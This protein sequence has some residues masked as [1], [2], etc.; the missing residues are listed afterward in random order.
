MISS[1]KKINNRGLLFSIFLFSAFT[2][3]F[4]STASVS[5]ISWN[6]GKIIDDAVFTNSNAMDPGSIQN[7]LNSKVPS[8]DTWGTQPSEFGGGTRAQYGASRGNPAP[9][10]CLK[11][12]SEGGRSAAQIIYDTGQEFQINP[13]VL[14]VLLQKEQGLVTDTWP[15]ANQYRTATGYGCPDSTPGVCNSEYYGFTNQV[16]WAARMFRAIMNNSPTWYTPYVL[17]NNYIQYNPEPSC[18]G[19]I[20]NI[21][22]RSTQALYNYTPYQPNQ[23]ALDAGWGT[24]PCG[25]YGNRNFKLYFES[26][27]G[28]L[29][30][31]N[32]Y[33]AVIK[34]P[35]SPA[36]YLQTS[37]G[38]YYIP[39]GE[40]L[41]AWG[42]D[43]LTPKLVAQSYLDSLPNHD[44]LDRLLKDDWGN[45]FFIDGAK[46]HYIRSQDHLALWNFNS[47]KAAQSLGL[48]YTMPGGEW[49]GRFARDAA[50]PNTVWLV[51]RGKKRP[52]PNGDILYQWGYG[53][54][55]HTTVSTA[56]LN[57][58]PTIADAGRYATDGNSKYII[59]MGRKLA[60]PNANTDNAL[61]GIQ[62][63][64]SYEAITL[65]HLRTENAW[66]FV[67]NT[68]NGRWYML[69][70]GKK[71][72]IPNGKLATIWGRSPDRPLTTVSDGYLASLTN[73]GDL[74]YAVQ[75]TN[76]SALWLI[77]G[78][79]HTIE[80]AQ[81]IHAWLG[82]TTPPVY[83][84]QSLA[85]LA[86][87]PTAGTVI[88]GYGSQF[89]YIMDGGKKRYLMSPNARNAW[90]HSLMV[91]ANEFVER[92]P[93][94]SFINY[95]VKNVSGQGYLLMNNVAY[96]IDPAFYDAWGISGTTPSVSD[97]TI[98]RY[99]TGQT[100]KAFIK[101]GSTSYVMINGNK[102]AIKQYAD[103][104][105]PS[106]LGEI[107]LPSDYFGSTSDASYLVKSN[108][109]ADGRMW[110]ITGGKKLL[111]DTFEQKVSYGY[112]SQG[113]QP[114]PLSPAT[115]SL[116]PNDT[117]S[118]SLLLQTGGTGVKF[119]SFGYALG[120]SE[121][122]TLTNAIGTSNPILQ[123]SPSVFETFKLRRSMT[124]LL[125]DDQG[126]LYWLESGNKRHLSS[127]SA[128]N[129]YSSTQQTYLEGTTMNLVPNGA[130]IN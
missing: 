21:E 126:K 56:Y 68:I 40:I 74:T 88:N 7:F 121:G 83:S 10:I 64:Q 79:K 24:A 113:I 66:Q 37:A 82:A 15:F 25:A 59:D 16:R 2:F 125:R 111:L 67:A 55:Q 71:H 44:W 42:L 20:V 104:Y 87:G 26:W 102:A 117:R 52:I 23:A 129:Q 30:H 34:T 120:F 97:E 100:L 43:K 49:I 9:F 3:S 36:L 54:S 108:D 94:G 99:T 80:G 78:R 86:T 50:Q 75:T 14:I 101:I 92:I 114:T 73:A 70:A 6:P 53:T 106:T 5:A 46:L 128:I 109:T 62:T 72:Y 45:L 130:A 118:P 17:G 61:Y 105:Q 77:D 103:A 107:T 76:P 119:I 93:E 63:P 58:M 81:S 95:I 35:D 91:S 85:H 29:T 47:S 51:D 12:F 13:Q 84:T 123:V 27:F 96:P 22:N 116:I 8:C 39:S 1:F 98:T 11:D 57:T 112:L 60:L 4:M 65:K 115:L 41:Q 31:P 32:L 18:G 28:P 90:T 48:V 122:V 89:T 19:S 127:Q 33:Y 69:E 124:R 110:V 38:K